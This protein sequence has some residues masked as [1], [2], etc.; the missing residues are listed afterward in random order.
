MKPIT[1]MKYTTIVLTFNLLLITFNSI[2]Q[3]VG[4]NA[5]GA[6]PDPSALLDLSSTNKGFLI[7]RVDTIS[8][9]SPAFGLMT[10]APSDSCLYMFNGTIWTSLGGVGKSCTCNCFS[11]PPPP[12]TG[13]IATS[14]TVLI[15]ITNA[16]TGKIWMDRNLGA[17]QVAT[18]STDTAAFGCLYQWG[19]S[20][21]GHE[22]RTSGTTATLSST[23]VPG[24]ANFITT[25]AAPSDW[26][27]PQNN[28]LWQGVVGINN[29]CPT[30]YRLPTEPELD[31][32][33]LSWIQAPINSTNTSTGAFSS[34]LK[35]TVG[36]FRG[37]NGV[38]NFIGLQG[39]YWSSTIN[40]T[41]ARSLY[42][43]I[44]N[45]NMAFSNRVYGISVRCIKN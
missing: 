36:G 27:N 29:P 20:P 8:I 11:P 6:A 15:P 10:L 35:L 34:P 9:I 44:G 43:S 22:Y 28:T 37:S 40:G 33:R 19:R 26:R 42:M 18:S 39:F 21:D 3:S 31:A 38:F 13:C 14:A 23:N 24:H 30:G 25:T 41:F 7:T 12:S 4:I 2:A 32:E 1:K 16:Y 17:S 45:A 5:I